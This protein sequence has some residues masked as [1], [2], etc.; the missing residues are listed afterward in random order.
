MRAQTRILYSLLRPHDGLGAQRAPRRRRQLVEGFAGDESD[1]EE[2]EEVGLTRI[3]ARQQGVPPYRAI[4]TADW[5]YVEYHNA[6]QERE[7]YDLHTD[8]IEIQSLHDEA[9]YAGVVQELSA[10]LATLEDCRAGTCRAAEDS[11]PGA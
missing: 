5:L 1:P 4:R 11:P 6:E 8:L 7:L 9:D 10:W 3:L 2:A